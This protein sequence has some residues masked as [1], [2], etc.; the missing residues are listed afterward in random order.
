MNV[1][2]ANRRVQQSGMVIPIG[3]DGFRVAPTEGFVAEI[4]Q[5]LAPN[6]VQLR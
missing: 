5:L 1:L 4:E 2:V 3:G 6:A